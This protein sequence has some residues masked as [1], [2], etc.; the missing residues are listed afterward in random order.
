MTAMRESAEAA[1]DTGGL[2]RELG[3]TMRSVRELQRVSLRQLEQQSAWSRST[4]SLAENGK[5]RPSRQLV[6]FY[7]D[8]FGSDGLLLSLFGEATHSGFALMRTGRQLDVRYPGDSFTVE[9]LSPPTGA[10]LKP[11]AGVSCAWTVRNTGSV[12]W[13]GRKLL[14]VGPY[15][16][17]RV[18]SGPP[19]VVLPSLAPGAAAEVRTQVTTPTYRGAVVAFWQVVDLD[20][21]SCFDDTRLF[22]LLVTVW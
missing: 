22:S 12:G 16:G 14:R 18:L 19:S 3:L 2:W 13:T 6:E 1:W 10:V 9:Q 4:L 15:G 8:R 20:E 17:P 7:E 11:N 21:V 5:A